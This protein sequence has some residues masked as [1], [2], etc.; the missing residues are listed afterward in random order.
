M[1]V[2]LDVHGPTAAA[3]RVVQVGRRARDGRPSWPGVLRDLAQNERE[4]FAEGRRGLWK[5]AKRSTIRRKASDN[6]PPVLMRASGDLQDSLTVI[7]DPN[8]IRR[9]T[10]T[11]LRFGT[12]VLYARWQNTDRPLVVVS[13]ATIGKVVRRLERDIGGSL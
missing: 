11:T 9:A 1:R 3:D 2:K 7:G 13:P 5:P 6:L 4:H 12:A 8:M 10:R